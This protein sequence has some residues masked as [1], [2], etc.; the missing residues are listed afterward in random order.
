MNWYHVAVDHTEPDAN[1][2]AFIGTLAHAS[3]A[4]AVVDRAGEV[5]DQVFL[6]YDAGTEGTLRI[7]SGELDV[8]GGLR[9]GY[10]GNG[11][12]VLSDGIVRVTNQCTVGVLSAGTGQCNVTNGSLLAD[13]LVVGDQGAGEVHQSGGAV[14]VSQ[15]MLI[16]GTS[17]TGTYQLAGGTLTPPSM[18]VG[19]RSAGVFVQTG[20]LLNMSGKTLSVGYNTGSTGIYSQAGGRI[21]CGFL[22]LGHLSQSQGGT[23]V[24]TGGTNAVQSGLIVGRYAGTTGAYNLFDGVLL[25]DGSSKYISIG[26]GGSGIFNLGTTNSAGIIQESGTGS[27]LEVRKEASA[28]GVL[29]GW[30]VIAI[31]GYVHNSGRIIANGYGSNR[32]LDLSSLSLVRTNSFVNTTSNGW[33]AVNRGRLL[34]PDLWLGT[35][36]RYWGENSNLDLVNS[37]SFDLAGSSGQLFGK[38]VAPDHGSVPGGLTSPVAVWEFSAAAPG[39]GVLTFRY[40][41]ARVSELGIPSDQLVVMRHDGNRWQ[42]VTGIRNESLKTLTTQAGTAPAGFFAVARR[43]ASSGGLLFSL[44]CSEVKP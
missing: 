31:S 40:D 30:G 10:R 37:V 26:Y 14:T 6:G 17:G 20:G 8:F 23:F 1:D 41:D 16:G 29:Q 43:P 11:T 24:Q 38:L 36:T 7:L 42:N 44:Q 4:T 19:D 21:Q 22:Y 33:Y 32:D 2:Y 5:S 18:Q 15:Q 3:S 25:L 34:L 39:A 12:L 35:G 28:A 9:V 27:Y 13:K